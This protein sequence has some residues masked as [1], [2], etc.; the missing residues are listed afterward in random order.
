[1]VPLTVPPNNAEALAGGAGTPSAHGDSLAAQV[2]VKGE[3]MDAP[4]GR[5]DDFA[6]PPGS[7]ANRPKSIA[8]TE[9]KVN[10]PVVTP[11]TVPTVAPPAAPP[12]PV[13]P[14]AAK[15]PPPPKP[16]VAVKKKPATH[17]RPR[18]ERTARSAPKHRRPP[19]RS[20]E[21][22]HKRPPPQRHQ[23]AFPSLFGPGGLF[24]GSR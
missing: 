1:V 11:P 5:A 8:A 16:E 22:R 12:P 13:A 4:A 10:V 7:K 6:W 9:S 14:V 17:A 24:G 18:S 21:T 3:P 19:P 23:P 2:L 20:A 15:P